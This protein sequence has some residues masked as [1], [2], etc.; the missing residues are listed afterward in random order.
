MPLMEWT[1]KLSVDV[2]EI[3]TQH[4]KWIGLLNDLHEAMKSGKGK[5]AVGGVLSGLVDYT[6]VHFA[7]EERLLKSNGYPLFDGHKRIHEDMVKE[8]ENLEKKYKTGQN[9]LSIDVMQ[10]LKNWL[11]EHIMG[12]DKNYSAFLR[13]K[14]IS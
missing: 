1:E 5:E 3:D 14:G 8:V 13:S 10:F 9:V 2:K 4:K 6:K 7:T 11:S 12:T